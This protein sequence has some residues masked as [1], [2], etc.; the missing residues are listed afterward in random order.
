MYDS[1]YNDH[2]FVF[3]SFSEIEG[4]EIEGTHKTIIT[5]SKPENDSVELEIVGDCRLRGGAGDAVHVLNLFFALYEKIG[6]QLKPSRYGE[7]RESTSRPPEW[8]G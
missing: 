1:L 6:L 8:F 2:N 3:T 7:N 5:F 4:K